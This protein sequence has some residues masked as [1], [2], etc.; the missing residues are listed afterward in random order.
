MAKKKKVCYEFDEDGWA[1]AIEGKPPIFDLVIVK[2]QEEKQQLAW[3]TGYVWDYGH[4]R[5]TGKI[6]KWKRLP[7]GYEPL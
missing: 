6:E 5:I 1:D 3:W 2:N 4:K 7:Q